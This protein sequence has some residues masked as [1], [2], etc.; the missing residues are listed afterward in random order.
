V[1]I[2]KQ[3]NIKSKQKL[4]YIFNKRAGAGNLKDY[5]NIL[6]KVVLGTEDT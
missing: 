4:Q 2:Q 6:R 1:K 5:G 3:N